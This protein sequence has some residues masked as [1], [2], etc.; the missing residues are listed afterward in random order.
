MNQVSPALTM[1]IELSAMA[2]HE[3]TE[4]EM[5]LWLSSIERFGDE[6][7]VGYLTHWMG[8]GGGYWPSPL[9][10]QRVLSGRCGGAD[11][12]LIRVHEEVASVGPYASPAFDDPVIEEAIRLLG[13]W[14][15]VCETMPE[16]AAAFAW[17]EFSKSFQ[18]AY[19]T[20]DSRAARGQI[21]VSARPLL[22]LVD[23]SRQL[24]RAAQ[25]LALSGAPV[26]ESR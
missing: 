18:A 5:R 2:H 24:G 7:V 8:S 1:A 13:G 25:T 22:G 16:E 12:A 20:A 14:L 3:C 23:A 10:C 21:D 6:A 17:K 19:A 4:T 26:E 15:K 11:E 9:V